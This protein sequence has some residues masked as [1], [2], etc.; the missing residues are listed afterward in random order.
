MSYFET[1]Y[2]S[3]NED[4]I[5]HIIEESA[6]NYTISC[7]ENNNIEDLEILSV[8]VDCLEYNLKLD[9][10]F[11][12]LI[13]ESFVPF[14]ENTSMI[15]SSLLLENE[16]INQ[17]N[18]EKK[19]VWQKIKSIPGAIKRGIKKGINKSLE[20]SGKKIGQGLGWAGRKVGE[21]I[22][23][24]LKKGISA[25]TGAAVDTA[26]WG[27]GAAAKGI[28][29]RL[30]GKDNTDRISSGLSG[31]RKGLEDSVTNSIKRYDD[32]KDKLIKKKE[33]TTSFLKHASKE[34]GKTKEEFKNSNLGKQAVRLKN[35]LSKKK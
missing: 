9:N 4:I 6:Y 3:V 25:G 10:I 7:F 5:E 34:F 19:T 23:T 13:S 14:I 30:I 16:E 17:D 24:G 22:K 32:T 29:N 11:E 26:V 33:S 21:G 18:P 27:A 35:F 2:E 20:W 15:Y 31:M 12:D 8:I 28:G 1:L